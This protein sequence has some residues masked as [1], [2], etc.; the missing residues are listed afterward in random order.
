[1]NEI[2][3]KD[4]VNFAE[5]K[6]FKIPSFQRDYVWKKNNTEIL[7]DSI[8]RE[9]PIGSFLFLSFD[10][11]ISFNYHEIEV[12][13]SW[14]E[15]E[16]EQK[17][18]KFYVLDGQQ[19]ITSIIK[20]MNDLDEKHI[21]C[22]NLDSLIKCIENIDDG[23][24]LVFSIKKSPKLN[25]DN[26]QGNAFPLSWFQDVHTKKSI[27]KIN[28][29]I[30]S[31]F[32]KNNFNYD[33]DDVSSL[34]SKISS[35]INNT[36]NY[37]IQVKTLGKNYSI[38]SIIRIFETINNSGAKLTVFD[39]LV[40][41][42]FKNSNSDFFSL[43]ILYEKIREKVDSK[44]LTESLFINYCLYMKQLDKGSYIN[45][46]KS[47][48]LSLNTED[49]LKC[50]KSF[51]NSFNNVNLFIKKNKIF[52]D[53]LGNIKLMLLLSDS[54][55]NIFK[56]NIP[57]YEIKKFIL[58]RIFNTE[59]YNRGFVNKD[60][61]FLKT[62]QQ[63]NY[64]ELFKS[65]IKFKPY[66]KDEILNI[67]RR[68]KE[69]EAFISIMHDGFD[70]DIDRK[71]MSNTK[72]EQHHIIPINFLIKN[73]EKKDEILNY[74]NSICNMIITTKETN[75]KI[76]DIS[77]FI[78]LKSIIESHKEFKKVFENN[79]IPILSLND[80]EKLEKKDEYLKFI[81]NRAELIC[82]RINLYYE[83]YNVEAAAGIEPAYSDLQSGT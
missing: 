62:I 61:N 33:E 13:N 41:K 56:R 72:L 25:I 2:N 53:D 27:K 68:S 18:D 10:S 29:F 17:K 22:I 5:K 60:F 35:K 24:E 19:R 54:K 30:K 16:D 31:Y 51:I 70:E 57:E 79:L 73:F 14:F 52:Y 76:I 49:F 4:L 48:L 7:I 3:L 21:Y 66:T 37:T 32:N 50:E 75:L 58:Y 63:N 39:L 82:K 44:D 23:E 43:K 69:Y 67:S 59:L 40:A 80:V 12:E 28:N 77:P 78:Y 65:E 6:S 45:L 26:L 20:A 71:A 47:E 15:K 42:T 64:K 9:Y 36:L 1:M 38:E 46:T 11:N 83:E 81:Y 55:L 74:K 34:Q 8:I